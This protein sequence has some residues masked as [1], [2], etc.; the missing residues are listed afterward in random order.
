LLKVVSLVVKK[1][2]EKTKPKVGLS[3]CYV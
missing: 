1:N 3:G 2:L